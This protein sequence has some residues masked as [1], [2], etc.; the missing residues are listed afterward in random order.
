[1]H[2]KEGRSIQLEY[3]T[4]LDHFHLPKRAYIVTFKLYSKEQKPPVKNFQGR[5]AELLNE[6]SSAN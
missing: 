5:W 3:C 4:S 2:S 1:M 6:S